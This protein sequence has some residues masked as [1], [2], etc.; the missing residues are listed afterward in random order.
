MTIIK[1]DIITNLMSLLTPVCVHLSTSP[2]S[3][4]EYETSS[5]FSNQIHEGIKYF[6]IYSIYLYFR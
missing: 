4:T 2:K 5:Y 3:I 1:L 6:S